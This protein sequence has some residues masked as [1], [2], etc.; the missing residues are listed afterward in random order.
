MESVAS[1]THSP[2]SEVLTVARRFEPVLRYTEGEL[3]LPMPVER[4]VESA[5]LYRRV[6]RQKAPDLV[7]PATKINLSTLVSYAGQGG[8][9]DLELH[10]VDKPLSRR[11]Y[12]R[13]RHR[14]DRPRFQGG[15]PFAMVGL[16]GR[17]I[18]SIMRFSLIVRGKVPGGFA[19]AAHIRYQE[20]SPAPT[21][22]VRAVGDSGY[23]VLQYWFFYAMNDWR[24]TFSGVN[25]HE[26]DWEQITLFL[27]EPDDGGDPEL[28]WVAF[29]SH[30]EV[31]DDLRRRVDDPDLQLIDGTHPVVHAGAGSH[32]GAYL[33]GDYIV[34]VAPPAL[35][36]LTQ[37]WRR[38]T[39][40][41]MSGRK[42]RDRSGIGLPFVDYRR[43]DGPSVGPGTERPWTAIVIDDETPWVRNYRGLWGYDTRDPFGGERAPAGPRYERNGSIRRSWDRPVAWAGLDKVPPT[44]TDEAAALRRRANDIAVEL[45]AAQVRLADEINRLRSLHE[46]RR[47]LAAE[48]SPAR[49]ADGAAQAAVDAARDEIGPQTCHRGRTHRGCAGL[50]AVEPDGL[51]AATIRIL[52]KL[53]IGASPGSRA[54]L[55]VARPRTGCAHAASPDTTRSAWSS[56]PE[57]DV[58]S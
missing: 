57:Y 29:S 7:A 19:A 21:Y 46:G 2:V 55:P 12:R 56:R 54:D 31:G 51:P 43:G 53:W 50:A 32:S 27:T 9:N 15:S 30:D 20:A 8:G 23:L 36:R 4:Y 3:F 10:F 52:I 38:L 28:A 1:L 49:A 35:E 14:P 41:I 18:D 22:Y 34:A 26:A 5:A 24:S 39:R 47:A 42:S 33:P 25:D 45:D 11:G 58:R 6:S 48:G 40:V 17:L 44:P 16:F 37:W 13:W